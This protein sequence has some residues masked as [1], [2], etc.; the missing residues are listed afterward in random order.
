MHK[1]TQGRR[2][3]ESSV[4]LA[5][6][7]ESES[8]GDKRESEEGGADVWVSGDPRTASTVYLPGPRVPPVSGTGRI[9]FPQKLVLVTRVEPCKPQHH[10]RRQKCGTFVCR[11]VISWVPPSVDFLCLDPLPLGPGYS[12]WVSVLCVRTAVTFLFVP[13]HVTYRLPD[14]GLP[15][16]VVS[17]CVLL[18]FPSCAGV[19]FEIEAACGV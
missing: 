10:D 14:T 9:V 15:E 19:P 6:A 3:D 2:C 7:T 5:L 12:H 17:T 11:P 16:T 8:H 13:S 18:T 1:T 4:T